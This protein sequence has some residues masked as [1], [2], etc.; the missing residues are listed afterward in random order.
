MK[1]KDITRMIQG[2]SLAFASVLVAAFMA[3]LPAN[4]QDIA[5]SPRVRAQMAERQ[6][7]VA[8]V[9]SETSSMA[10][11]KC[12]EAWVAQVD[13]NPRGMGARTLMGQTTRLVVRH[14]CEGCGTQWTT[15]GTSKGLH[16]VA[17]H[18][19]TSCGADSLACCGSS[20]GSRAATQGMEK[21]PEIA[22]IK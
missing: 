5:A 19:C 6:A 17:S 13:T 22:P 12:I 7:T 11:P 9:V 2:P 8:P 1:T 3:V 18:K 16:A 15:A 14:L 10:C 20:A 21:K 4:A